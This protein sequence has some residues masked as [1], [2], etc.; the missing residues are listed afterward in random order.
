VEEAPVIRQASLADAAALAAFASR[1]FGEVFGPQNDAADMASYL[2]EAFAPHIQHAEIATPGSIVLLAE[3]PGTREI[4]GYAHLVTAE[5]P[6]CVSGPS[7]IELKRLYVD[8]AI[9]SRGLGKRL[10]DE[11]IARAKEAGAETVWLGVWEHNGKAQRF[12]LREGF[13]RA[14]EHAFVLGSDTQTDWIMQ[15]SLA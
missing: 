9:H 7:P 12:Y 5:A 11:A 4:V 2:A 10:L 3:R 6:A 1:V 13:T 14:G 8:P 15:R